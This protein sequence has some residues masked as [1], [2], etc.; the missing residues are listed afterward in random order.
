MRVYKDTVV[1][2]RR[3]VPKGTIIMREGDDGF[4]A[5][6]LQSG[7]VEVF[8]QQDGKRRVFGPVG[9]GEIFGEMALFNLG[10][11]TASVE[12]TDDCNLI[13][14]TRQ[15]L[16]EKL[17]KSD[18]TVRAIVNMMIRRLTH[19][20]DELTNRKVLID[21]FEKVL[22]VTY[23]NMHDALPGSVKHRFQMDIEPLMNELVNRMQHYKTDK[24]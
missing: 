14:I 23:E 20:N 13:L 5:Y 10:K 8:S 2:E 12:A 7:S 4:H 16:E 15:A 9:P 21:D 18:G 19:G 3:F 1:L 11:R 22:R 24:N 17:S 6:L